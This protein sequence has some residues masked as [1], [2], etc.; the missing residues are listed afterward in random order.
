MRYKGL[1][2]RSSIIVLLILIAAGCG[3]GGGNGD[4]DG[5]SGSSVTLSWDAPTKNEDGSDLTDLLGYK[6]YYGTSPSS[7]RRKEL[8]LY[9]RRPQGGHTLLFCGHGVRYI[10]K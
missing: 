7:L 9:N 2:C 1:F 6:V 4:S 5:A 3:S 8:N 10:R